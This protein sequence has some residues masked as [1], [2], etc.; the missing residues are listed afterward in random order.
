MR[1]SKLIEYV[2]R[3]LL[4]VV[5]GLATISFLPDTVQADT[6]PVD[7]VLGGTGATSW[8]ITTIQ[9]ADSGTRTVELHNAGSEDGFVTIWLSDIISNEGVNPESETGDTAEPGE[10][11]EYLLLDL[12]ADGL[13]TNLDLPTVISNLP[14]S[15]T[16]SNYI[17]VIPLMTGDTIN[18]QWQWELPVQ[19]G[20]DV[21]GDNISFTINYLLRECRVTDTSTVVTTEGV[22]TD[23]I[24][25]ESESGKGE[26]TIEEGTT[27][28]TEEGV[29]L[30]KIWVIESDKEPPV[31]P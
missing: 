8:Y 31:V 28:L 14:Q 4:A 7:L 29:P 10:V 12:T 23:N 16:A 2:A 25:A 6:N 21:Q 1:I 13:N 3:L 26:L 9:P 17:E 11:A 19:T 24:T 30:S 15:Y 18:L 5:I 22:F 20:N 27:G